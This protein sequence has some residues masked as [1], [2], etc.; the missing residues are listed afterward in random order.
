V[1]LKALDVTP[2]FV[3]GF[4]RL[5]YGRLPVDELVQLKALDITPDFVQ[6]VAAADSSLPPVNKLV[7]L[8][9]FGRR[10]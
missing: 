7:E 9:T 2:E 1:Q 5:G 6:R 4:D 3:A 8:K 10:H